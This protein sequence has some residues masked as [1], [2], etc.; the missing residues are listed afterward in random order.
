MDLVLSG[1][2]FLAPLAILVWHFCQMIFDPMV[3]PPDTAAID[4]RQTPGRARERRNARL[5]VAKEKK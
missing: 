5:P 3:Y 4:G 2:R 1:C